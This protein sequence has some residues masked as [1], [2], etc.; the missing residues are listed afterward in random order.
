MLT[1]RQAAAG[2]QLAAAQVER[3]RSLLIKGAARVTLSVRRILV[4]LAAC[5]LFATEIR[6]AQRL[7]KTPA[8]KLS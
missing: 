5:C 3:L 7:G 4:E 6:L 8:L 2:T 1:I